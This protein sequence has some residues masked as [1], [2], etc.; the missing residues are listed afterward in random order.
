MRI[1]KWFFF[2]AW[3]GGTLGIQAGQPLPDIVWRTNGPNAH[4]DVV[5]SVAFSGDSTRLASGANDSHGKVWT[6]PQGVLL[7]DVW[8]NQEHVT[9]IGQSVNG[10]LLATGS[11]DGKTRMW[12]VSDGRRLWLGGPDDEIVYSTLF[13]PDGN[14]LGIGRSDGINLRSPSTGGG[15][16]FG[17]HEHAEVYCVDFSPDGTLLASAQDDGTASL[18]RVP[19]GTLVFDFTGHSYFNPTNEEGHIINAVRAVDFSPDGTLVASAGDEA[20]SGCG[21]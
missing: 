4:F 6:V 5:R 21:A 1:T 7:R 9:A 2:S 15:F 16:P 14:Y 17:E 13:S 12:Q 10:S 11:D 3:V 19:Q 20:P 8:N 18:W